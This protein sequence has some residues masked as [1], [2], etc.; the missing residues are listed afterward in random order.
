MNSRREEI[1]QKNAL[2]Y[3]HGASLPWCLTVYS[4]CSPRPTQPGLKIFTIVLEG[5]Q[6]QLKKWLTFPSTCRW[7]HCGGRAAFWTDSETSDWFIT[8]STSWKTMAT[9]IRIC[10]NEITGLQTNG[11]ERSSKQ[12]NKS[13]IHYLKAGFCFTHTILP[14]APMANATSLLD[15]RCESPA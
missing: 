9:E 8:I 13:K 2:P 15:T 4:I 1:T 6:H 14:F 10:R 7:H 11:L 3:P 5:K 12:W